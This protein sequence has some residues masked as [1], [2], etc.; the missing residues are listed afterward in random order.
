PATGADEPALPQAGARNA[1]PAAPAT[2]MVRRTVADM[3]RNLFAC[4]CACA[5]G[6]TIGSF[7][8]IVG[9]DVGLMS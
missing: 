9:L 4:A 8:L 2:A 1:S 5:S 6:A 7:V 3:D